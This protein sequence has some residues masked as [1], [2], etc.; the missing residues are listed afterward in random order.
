MRCT[1]LTEIAMNLHDLR[2]STLAFSAERSSLL[3]IAPQESPMNPML[4]P[5]MMYQRWLE[6]FFS[7]PKPKPTP[8]E[9]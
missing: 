6:I 8:Y 5:L 7:Q 3:C 2:Q 4:I 1:R 9:G